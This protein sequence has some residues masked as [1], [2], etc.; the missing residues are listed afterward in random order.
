MHLSLPARLAALLAV[1]VIA[2]ACSS[3]S[4]SAGAG[5]IEISGSWAR[6]SPMVEGA[7][8][9]YMTIKNT[10]GAADTLVGASSPAAKSTEVHE[11]YVVEES[12]AASM[13]GGMASPAASS[14]M[15]SGSPMM[16]M[17]KI[18]SLEIP[19]GGSVE[20]KP[21]SY[22]LMLLELTAPL[23]AG[24]KI[25]ITLTF[26]NAGEVKVTADVKDM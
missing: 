12:P 9:A 20:L 14:G 18:D 16:G 25:D 6:T 5:K 26:K 11:T 1:V 8:A 24:E 7:G 13:G 17:R 10:G 3:G 22:H 23:K 15:G 21:G 4:G 19:A 2:G